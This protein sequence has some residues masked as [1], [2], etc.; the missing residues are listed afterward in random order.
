MSGVR[1]TREGGGREEWSR[2]K[3][4]CKFCESITFNSGLKE[5]IPCWKSIVTDHDQLT[6]ASIKKIIPLGTGVF[7]RQEGMLCS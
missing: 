2:I 4:I 7:S 1:D 3:N 5:C 6:V